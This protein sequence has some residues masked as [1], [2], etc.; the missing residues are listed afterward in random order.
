MG[1]NSA[2]VEE[3][4]EVVCNVDWDGAEQSLDPFDGRVIATTSDS[5]EDPV[6]Y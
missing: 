2:W 6:C 3:L 5:D 1:G 4:R